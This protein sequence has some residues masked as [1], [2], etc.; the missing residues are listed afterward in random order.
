MSK[1]SSEESYDGDDSRDCS[2]GENGKKDAKVS[3]KEKLMGAEVPSVSIDSR[4][5]SVYD[6]AWQEHIDSL[7]GFFVGENGVGGML[8]EERRRRLMVFFQH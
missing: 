5:S 8:K 1:I 3:F 4:G 7:K 2:G 6:V